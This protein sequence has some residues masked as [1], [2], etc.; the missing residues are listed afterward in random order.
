MFPVSVP[1]FPITN[2]RASFKFQIILM[3]SFLPG[4]EVVRRVVTIG[5]PVVGGVVDLT[6]GLVVT[7]DVNISK[8]RRT[9]YKQQCRPSYE[10]SFK[11]I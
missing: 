1:L 4:P 9:S 7:I 10:V 2:L 5:G 6:I 8:G 11:G 3:K